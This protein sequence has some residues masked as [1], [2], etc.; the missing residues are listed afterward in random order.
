MASGAVL[1]LPARGAK[2]VSPILGEWREGKVRPLQGNAPR[3]R[4]VSRG[5]LH[6]GAFATI[7]SLPLDSRSY[8]YRAL[9]MRFWKAWRNLSVRC[10]QNKN[11]PW[12]ETPL[13]PAG[14][15]RAQVKGRAGRITPFSSSA[16][17]S[18]R[19]FLDRVGRHQS[20]SPLHRRPQNN[21]H[22]AKHSAKGDISTLPG[23][24][25]FY[26][27]LTNQPPSLTRN[28]AELYLWGSTRC[29]AD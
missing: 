7:P 18:D 25:H 3:D 5:C 17:S 20:P 23:R 19:L 1:R 13:P 12:V 29:L 2:R 10:G 9:G 4:P 11:Q 26:F 6:S 14:R 8:P 22:P 28:Q 16:M 15:P 21:T 27:A 24:G